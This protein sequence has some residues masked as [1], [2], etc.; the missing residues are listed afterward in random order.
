MVVAVHERA[1]KAKAELTR[2]HDPTL[3]LQDYL[4]GRA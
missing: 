2:Q 4:G 1:L 3:S